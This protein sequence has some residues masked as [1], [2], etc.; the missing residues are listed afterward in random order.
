MLVGPRPPRESRPQGGF[1]PH[2]P[3]TTHRSALVKSGLPGRQSTAAG[4]PHPWESLPPKPNPPSTRSRNTGPGGELSGAPFLKGF[5]ATIEPTKPAFV[6][7]GR[8]PEGRF[9]PCLCLSSPYWASAR[10]PA[11]P[12]RAIGPARSTPRPSGPDSGRGTP[13]FFVV[14]GLPTAR[15]PSPGPGSTLWPQIMAA[16]ATGDAPRPPLLKRM[17]LAG[18][19]ATQP[20]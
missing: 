19:S 1:L 8:L 12:P 3:K 2:P 20:E 11:P 14:E 15:H 9:Y 7:L 10:L 16:A 17:P 5:V 6:A 4:S 18:H 13:P